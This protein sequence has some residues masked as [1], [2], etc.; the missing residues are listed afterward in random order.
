MELQYDNVYVIMMVAFALFVQSDF[1]TTSLITSSLR[2]SN[3]NRILVE[4]LGNRHT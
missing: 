4:Y 2:I 3:L 1:L